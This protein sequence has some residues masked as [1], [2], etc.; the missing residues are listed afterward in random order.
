M[1]N[2]GLTPYQD[3]CLTILMEECGETVQEICKI[4]RFGLTS[5]SHHTLGSNHLTCLEQELGDIIALI[6]IVRDSNIGITAYGLEQAKQK[7]L[8]KVNNWMKHTSTTNKTPSNLSTKNNGPDDALRT[9]LTLSQKEAT[10]F[11][12]K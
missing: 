8:N 4:M 1:S 2:S 10:K 3:E 9:V 11:K 7:K 5:E 12:E 6:E